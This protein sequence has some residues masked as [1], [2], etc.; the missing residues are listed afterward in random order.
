M[1]KV[2]RNFLIR[3]QNPFD[4]PVECADDDVLGIIG[5]ILSRVSQMDPGDR[6]TIECTD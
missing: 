1:E 5:E 4:T 3:F 2:K 6:I